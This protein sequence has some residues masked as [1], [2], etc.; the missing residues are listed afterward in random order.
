MKPDRNHSNKKGRKPCYRRIESGKGL[1]DFA[2]SDV[3]DATRPVLWERDMKARELG[4][5]FHFRVYLEMFIQLGP[6][7]IPDPDANIQS[8]LSKVRTGA[9]WPDRNDVGVYFFW[10]KFKSCAWSAR[11]ITTITIHLWHHARTR[12]GRAQYMGHC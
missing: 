8:L 5:E 12:R 7:S 1:V 6:C 10:K 2:R 11:L 9:T 4:H 3:P